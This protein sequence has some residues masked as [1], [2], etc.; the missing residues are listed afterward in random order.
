MTNWRRF[1]R[2]TQTD[3]EQRVE[4]QSYIDLTAEEYIAQGM[5]PQTARAAAKRKLGNTTL[6]R[7]EVYRMNTL[8]L[9][10]TL[11]RDT[12]HAFRSF[13]RNP[14]FS[15]AAV[16]SLALGIGAN[17]A[18][19]S[20]INAVLVRPLPYPNS[21]A[22]I[23]VFNSGAINGETFPDMALAS[24]MYAALK[25][26][27]TTFERFG[28]WE[29]GAATVT[30]LGDP[31]EIKTIAMTQGVLPTLEVQPLLGRAFSFDD[32]SPGSPQTVILSYGYWLRRFGGNSSAL[33]RQIV[34]DSIPRQIIG[35]MPQS[36]RF[37]DRSPDVLLP[38]RFS[39]TNLRFEPFRYSGIARL[40]PGV[41]LAQAGQD[42]ARIF[43][44]VMP[45][46]LK[47]F[48][49][50]AKF[51]PNFRPLKSDVIGD[52]G[53]TLRV[54][55]GA[56]AIIFFLVCA[57]VA[58]LVLVRAQ[59]RAQ[60]FA[61]RAALGSGWARIAGD[62][63]VECLCLGMI[64]G[65]CGVAAAYAAI[66]I[67]KTQ[68]LANIP[69]LAE[70]EIDGSALEFALAC[71]IFAS[72]LFGLAAILKYSK[73]ATIS[74]VRGATMTTEQSRV[75]NSFASVQIALA[76][77]LLIVGGLLMRSFIAVRAVHPGFNQPDQVQTARISIPESGAPSA[78]Q[79]AQIQKAILEKAATIP[80][81]VSAAFVD[82][83]PMDPD[84]HNGSLIAVED[85]FIPGQMPPNRNVKNVSPAFFATIGTRLLAGRDF[86]WDDLAQHREV[87]LVSENL[88][89]EYWGQPSA[90][91]GKRLRPGAF[92]DKWL[93]IIG[94]VEDVHDDGANKQA[95]PTVYFRTGVHDSWTPGRPPTIRRDLTL[96]I[97]SSR[98]GSGGY[99]KEV[100]A[101]IH[102]V[103]PSLPLAQAQTLGE[104]YRRSMART[105]F[106]LLLLGIA[107]AVSLT[108]AIIGVYGVL[109]Y[110]VSRRRREVSIRMALGAEPY[111]VKALFL[112]RGLVIAGAG[113]I[114]GLLASAMVSRSLASL[115]FGV[116]V[117][118]PATYALSAAIVLI[119][120]LTASYIPS[121]R[122]TSLD[123]AESL[124][125][126]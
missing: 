98:T 108:L 83:L 84:H 25:E 56:L 9:L 42:A 29:T 41:T 22:L 63:I 86:T 106:T 62:L 66:G 71:S 5:D 73:P 113:M 19:F 89:R 1:F 91:I 50:Q 2:R 120:A 61:V 85:R 30:R 13:R 101:A 48:A 26:H 53:P 38:L 122:A 82:G 111:Q 123:P 23:G 20:V 40:K 14:G 90:A 65:A 96:A 99:L 81:V 15:T 7:E 8:T 119:A 88:A 49:A 75:Q 94:V 126:E 112:R 36:F 104:I 115:L 27:S 55:A 51:A 16:L 34:I 24:G 31:E 118:D 4:L 92:G 70:V 72:L 105:S 45:A 78:E 103:N 59:M 10:E 121:S 3:D 12:R 28:V 100:S 125:T 57:N 97:R 60:E 124:R 58:N 87:A 43:D 21:N 116:T 47:A 17:L 39:K 114:A 107:S 74:N 76:M 35:V 6:I 46:D 80:G 68:H 33:S 110:A 52:I 67:L 44:Q 109:A 102:S 64:G 32:D 54:L 37:L 69:R 18:I 77:V 117:V 11:L 79:V 93:A 95:P